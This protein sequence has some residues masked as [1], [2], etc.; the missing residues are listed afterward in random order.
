MDIRASYVN[1]IANMQTQL[2]EQ[3]YQQ[4]VLVGFEA[5]ARY[6][7]QTG[8]PLR[9]DFYK[10]EDMSKRLRVTATYDN[11]RMQF[12]ENWGAKNT[13][14]DWHGKVFDTAAAAF[15]YA[16]V[17]EWGRQ[18][19]RVLTDE[20]CNLRLSWLELGGCSCHLGGAPCSSCT[21]PGNPRSLAE[22]PA[23]WEWV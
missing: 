7:G 8:W 18:N 23:M 1:T 4:A 22:D 3:L 17:E 21:H 11:L 16:E 15:V 9:V 20:G 6:G 12:V 19:R 2:L 5:I 13:H 14:T 10:H